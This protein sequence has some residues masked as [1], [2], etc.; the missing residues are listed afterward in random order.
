MSAE[1]FLAD[2]IR[3]FDFR[4]LCHFPG[5]WLLSK[6]LFLTL[7]DAYGCKIVSNPD[8]TYTCTP[9]NSSSQYEVHVL[10]VYEVIDR[11]PPRA[12]NARVNIIS[13]GKSSSPIVLVLV[14]YEPVN[15]ILNIPSDITI[16]KVI[17]VSIKYSKRLS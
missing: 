6:I 7:A 5:F 9:D 17:L 11:R 14:S 4:F 16:C 8:T 1:S 13:R 12:G 10:A 3:V 15:W 2:N